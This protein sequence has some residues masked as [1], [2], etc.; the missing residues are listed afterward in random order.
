MLEN[1]FIFRKLTLNYLG[2]KNYHVCN[3]V[4][5]SSGL[6]YIFYIQIKMFYTYMYI[7]IEREKENKNYKAFM[8]E[9]Q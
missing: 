6:I 8:A 1:I 3:L 9:S 7:Y 5:H 2:V 4:K